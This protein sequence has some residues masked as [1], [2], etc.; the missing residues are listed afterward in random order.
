M[1]YLFRNH[2][3]F[4]ALVLIAVF[5][6]FTCKTPRNVVTA[7]D[8]PEK[9][10]NE[11]PFNWPWRG[12]SVQ[13]QNTK[14][15]DIKYLA[16]I[17]VNSIRIQLKP[18]KRTATEG[19]DPTEN[20][21]KEIK[22][23]DSLM[24]E[25]KKHSI[26]S[27]LA[28][29]FPVLD[30]AD[31]TDDKSPEFWNNPFYLD[32]TYK[33]VAILA[34][35][36]KNRGDEFSTYE[37]LG[38]PAIIDKIKTRSPEKLEEFYKQVL[39]QIRRH[40]SRRWLLLTP[41]PWGKPTNYRNFVPFNI[42]DPHLIYG[43]HMYLPD[44][45]THQGVKEREKGI[46]YPGIIK[47]EYF[48]RSVIVKKF[49]ALIAFEKKFNYPVYIGEF[50]AAR[51]SDGAEIW[52]KD[53]ISVMDSLGWSWSY[54]AFKAGQKFWDPYYEVNDKNIPKEKWTLRYRG[55]ETEQWN[56]MIREFNK[57]KTKGR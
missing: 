26:T 53:V 19:G 8:V 11:V 14:A 54:F 35:H 3:Y 9:N 30:P 24:D 28:F 31:S 2:L 39:K 29:N 44:A 13:S 50:Q 16:E 56:N 40:D 18:S 22:W 27:I 46:S 25:A 55:P 10:S 32:S 37:V 20:F 34:A 47:G 12:I 23:A 33:L 21:Y 17:G 49:N 48:D 36:Y 42:Q 4:G 43:A 7:G 15:A 6:S 38:E 5:F 57:N 45:F 51:W 52:V 41:G 1:N